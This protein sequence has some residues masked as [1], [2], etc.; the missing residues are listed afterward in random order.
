M[1]SNDINLG[2]GLSTGMLY[3]APAD[4]ALPT[5]PSAAIPNTWTKAG[6]VTDAGITLGMS[7]SVTNLKN[8]ANEIKRVIMTEHVETIQSPLMDTTEESLEFCMGE[9][10][11][12]VTAATSSVG[13]IVT[14]DLSAGDLP[15]PKA[16]LW[17][18]KDGDD[19]LMIGCKKGQVTA[20]D[21]VTF[22]PGSSIT[23]TPTITA[24]D[25][26]MKFIKEAGLSD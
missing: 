5:T 10:N 14:V 13:K 4:T 7:K 3:T 20:V 9:D 16:Y 15:A 8:W 19:M 26:S 23:W 25:G 12:T 1:A 24:L 6:N 22:A 17:I 11:V 2:L 18:M 21:N